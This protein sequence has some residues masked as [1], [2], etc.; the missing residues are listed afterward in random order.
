MSDVKKM[1]DDFQA[2]WLPESGESIGMSEY[3]FIEDFQPENFRLGLEAIVKAAVERCKF[4]EEGWRYEP[5]L[6]AHAHP[7]GWQD[8][9]KPKRD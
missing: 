3:E 1:M 9:T 2:C 6:H 4:C 7:M 8:C 5:R